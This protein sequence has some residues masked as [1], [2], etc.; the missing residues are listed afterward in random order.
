MLRLRSYTGR[1]RILSFENALSLVSRSALDKG[2]EDS[3][4]EIACLSETLYPRVRRFPFRW[5]RVTRTLGTRLGVMP[6]RGFH[7]SCRKREYFHL[8]F[9]LKDVYLTT[10]YLTMG[11]FINTI[12]FVFVLYMC[13]CLY[14]S[15]HHGGSCENHSEEK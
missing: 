2:N 1:T 11:V 15:R 13:I 9:Y 4:D 5:I 3:G 12:F 8:F 10:P 14:F 6:F 7:R